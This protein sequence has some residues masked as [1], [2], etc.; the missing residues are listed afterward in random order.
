MEPYEVHEQR[1]AGTQPVTPVT[2][3]PVGGVASTRYG[4]Y[5]AA[6]RGIQLVWLIVGIVD[7]IIGLDF[8]FRALKANDTGFADLIYAVGGALA[9]PFDGIF[10]NT[11]TRSSYILRW[12]DILAILIYTLIGFGIVKLIRIM[13]SPRAAA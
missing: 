11:V 13:A 5:P 7:T 3:A 4:V 9:A 12:S 10:G 1:V 6:Y 2:G 8:L